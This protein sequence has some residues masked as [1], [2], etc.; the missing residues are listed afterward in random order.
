MSKEDALETADLAGEL[1][2]AARRKVG[3]ARAR[4]RKR[5]NPL[6]EVESIRR[7]AGRAE[8]DLADF[9]AELEASRTVVSA[10]SREEINAATTQLQ[11]IRNLSAREAA[12]R[13]GL[14]KLRDALAT[15]KSLKNG[16]KL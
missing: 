10:P 1:I 9:E 15:A 7:A 5:G 16:I 13:T 2:M 6:P 11:E 12:T 14:K 4:E 8:S 3:K